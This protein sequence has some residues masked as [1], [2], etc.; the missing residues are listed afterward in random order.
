[1]YC[2]IIFLYN[3]YVS[4]SLITLSQQKTFLNIPPDLSVDPI[5]KPTIFFNVCFTEHFPFQLLGVVGRLESLKPGLASQCL[6]K[7]KDPDN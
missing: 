5:S 4:V 7:S 2:T 3:T 1:M 6:V